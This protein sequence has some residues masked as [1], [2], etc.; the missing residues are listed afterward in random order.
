MVAK[1]LYN[2]NNVNMHQHRP[3]R[4]LFFDNAWLTVHNPANYT[5]T[6]RN[7]MHD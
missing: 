4:G 7:N 6:Y 2:M 1:L 5:A 3:L